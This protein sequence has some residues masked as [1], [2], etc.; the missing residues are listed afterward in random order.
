MHFCFYCY[1]IHTAQRGL[2]CAGDQMRSNT[3]H[4]KLVLLKQD[5]QNMT[6]KEKKSLKAVKITDGKMSSFSS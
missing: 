1:L 5:I 6:G 3:N 4:I 2:F